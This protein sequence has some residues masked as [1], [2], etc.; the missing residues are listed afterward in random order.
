MEIVRLPKNEFRVE[1]LPHFVRGSRWRTEAMRSYGHPILI[2]F[3]KGQGRIT[4]AGVT[5]GYG[6][7]NAVLIPAGTMHGFDMLGQVHGFIVH[8]PYDADIDLPLDPVHLRFRAAAQHSELNGLI[9]NLIREGE[10]ELAGQDRALLHYGGL[11][12]VW[13]QRQIDLDPD[14]EDTPDASRRLAAAYTAL[15][16]RDFHLSKTVADYASDLGITP[17][18]LSRICNIACGRPASSILNERVHFEAR[19]LLS[20][21]KSPVKDIAEHL[22]FTSAAYFTR[23]FQKSSGKTPSSFRKQG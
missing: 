16:E 19:R 9:D 20:D 8:F 7:H 13:L 2:W 5:R 12:S 15:V 3:T 23:A 1:P 10:R 18:H 21:T 6:P 17:T 14:S 22:G 4:V 11:L